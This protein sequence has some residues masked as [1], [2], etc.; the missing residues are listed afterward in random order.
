MSKTSTIRVYLV[1]EQVGGQGLLRVTP[2]RNGEPAPNGGELVAELPNEAAY[3]M[4]QR[5]LGQ[6]AAA[7]GVLYQ[8]TRQK[9]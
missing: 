2:R 5:Q 4:L 6:K 9:Q 1:E 8:P 7:A 3:R